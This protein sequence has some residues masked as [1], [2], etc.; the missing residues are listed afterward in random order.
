MPPL[1]RLSAS[2]HPASGLRRAALA[3]LALIA[4][5]AVHAQPRPLV[6]TPTGRIADV[7]DTQ[8]VPTATDGSPR[9]EASQA[10][11]FSV[12]YDAQYR[13]INVAVDA[14]GGHHALWATLY[15]ATSSPV[16]YAYCPSGLDCGTRQ[17]WSATPI[18]LENDYM[19]Q[20]EVT[21]DG[22]PRVLATD[23]DLE[24]PGLPFQTR[25]HYASCEAACLSAGNWTTTELWTAE[26]GQGFNAGD[27]QPEFFSLDPQG[28]PRFVYVQSIDDRE[29]Y[30]AGCDAG[31]TAASN[32]WRRPMPAEGYDDYETADLEIGTDGLPRLMFTA[33]VD[34][35]TWAAYGECAA[36]CVSPGDW[37]MAGL[38]SLS[39]DGYCGASTE[40][41][42]VSLALDGADRPRIAVQG[43]TSNIV[44][45]WCQADCLDG[46]GWGGPRVF[47]RERRGIPRRGRGPGRAPVP[48]LPGMG[49]E[50]RA[51][52][53]VV[54]DGLLRPE[55]DVEVRDA[56]RLGDAPGRVRDPPARAVRR[57][58]LAGRF[59]PIARVPAGRAA[60]RRA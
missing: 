26:N 2:A 3:A 49:R 32:W 12:G 52:S 22:R 56:R 9:R 43:P 47:G 6:T 38:V 35:A 17:G 36:P 10:D 60:R 13:S 41:C 23:A 33:L 34:G 20:L 27:F 30:Y 28:R 42:H 39:P 57:G 45:A 21:P 51:F 29:A 5:L 1:S 8:T 44:A 25:Y 19:L 31:C 46:A 4:P 58:R 7:L 48:R 59:P 11:A 16:V 37:A 55:S 24:I 15:G 40:G 53:R 14:S 18:G 50:R 54:R